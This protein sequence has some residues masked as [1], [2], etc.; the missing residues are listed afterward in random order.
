MSN[1]IW[2]PAEHDWTRDS[3]LARFMHRQGFSALADLRLAAVRHPE[4]FWDVALR[5][6]NL[7]WTQF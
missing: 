4:W 7:E 2:R 3:H 1:F 5:D 6:L